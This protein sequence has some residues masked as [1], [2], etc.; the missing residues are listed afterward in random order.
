LPLEVA[1]GGR[2]HAGLELSEHPRTPASGRHPLMPCLGLVALALAAYSNSFSGAF[3]LDDQSSIVANPSLSRVW[4]P[5]A[6]LF[7]PSAG[8]TRGRPFA[9]LT[10]ALNY[11]FGGL[12]VGGYHAVNLAFHVLAGLALFGIM[13]RTLSRPVAG[14][15]LAAAAASLAFAVAALWLV[16]PLTT[17]AVT[18]LS[19]RTESL[20]GLLY[21]LTLYCVIRGA[22]SATSARWYAAATVTSL[23]G[24][25][26]KE[27]MITAPVVILFYDR[28]FLAGSFAAAWRLRWRLY[29]GLAAGWILL[30][31]LMV[32]VGSRG[33]GMALGVSA[34][35]YALCES[36]AVFHYL[37]LA[38]WPRPLVFDYGAD[39]GPGWTGAAPFLLATVAIVAATFLLLRRRPP[40]GF[41]LFW[42]LAVLAPTSSVVPVV[43]QPVAEHR[44]YLPLI[45]VIALAVSTLYLLVGRWSALPLA[46]AV[47]LLGYVTHERNDDYRSPVAI[48]KDTVAKRPMNARAHCNL[49][50]ALLADGREEGGMRELE[51]ALR[52]SPDDADSNLDLGVAFGN[53]GRLGEAYPMIQKAA[54]ANPSLAEA[55]FDLGWIDARM[56][57]EPDALEEY[58]RAIALRPDYVDAHCN[59][60]D[61]LV[62]AGLYREALPHYEAALALGP[63]NP[64]L[65]YNEAYAEVRSG[66][67][68]AAIGDYKR[69]LEL[70]PGF[71]EA[72]RN[73]DFLEAAERKSRVNQG[74]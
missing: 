20:M 14:P 22:E 24:M 38:F 73:L 39:L 2:H 10:F 17:E 54:A 6:P 30:G 61:L 23:L 9:N 65:Y 45:A 48:W 62:K 5:W 26:T 56:G 18:Y 51:A 15:R 46:A 36:R 60:A 59:A 49:G 69:A 12:S 43:L 29:V 44:M 25:A 31:F 47:L 57:R 42:F 74:Q 27:V 58:T 37:G 11:W 32:G 68:D 7:S 41:A 35:S 50:N 19:Q 71:P 8:G 53:L 72:K 33:A 64:D 40:V 3:I 21:L 4:P 67:V 55:H 66:H 28:T 63:P 34:S 16:H 13:R 1:A 52:I 70:R